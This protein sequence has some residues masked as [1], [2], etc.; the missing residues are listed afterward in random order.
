LKL[1]R[2]SFLLILL[3][4]LGTIFS[5]VAS[6]KKQE[7]HNLVAL[8]DSI[9]FG[10]NLEP[11]QIK[12]SPRAFPNLID[13]EEFKV[14]NLGVPGWT[15]AELLN[16]LKTNPVFINSLNTAD[17]VT[18]NIGSNDF[19]QAAGLQQLLA[20]HTPVQDTQQ[21]ELQLLAAQQQLINNLPNIITEIKKHTNAPIIFYNLYNPIGASTD[22]V[23]GSLHLLGEQFIP[24]INN[25]I[26]KPIAI[27]SGALLVDAYST[28]NG[29]EAKYILPGDVHPSFAGHKALAELADEALENLKHEEHDRHHSK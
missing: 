7:K 19:I 13:K 9:T 28:F 21:L 6:A 4:A 5:S 2:F 15:S 10:Y 16:A 23:I 11:N 29:K 12:P 14:T 27:Q 24:K 17:V 3:L 25:F 8:G 20:T 18:L 1:K 26:Y 22:P